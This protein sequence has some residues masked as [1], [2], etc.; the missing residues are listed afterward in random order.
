MVEPVPFAG[1]Y[2]GGE[3]AGGRVCRFLL[4]THPTDGRSSA[5]CLCIKESIDGSNGLSWHPY[6]FVWRL[7]EGVRGDLRAGPDR[8]GRIA[9]RGGRPGLLRTKTK[10]MRGEHEG[11]RIGPL[12][13]HMGRGRTS[14][15]N[16]RQAK[17]RRRFRNRRFRYVTRAAGRGPKASKR[18]EPGGNRQSEGTKAKPRK[19]NDSN[20]FRGSNPG[21]EYEIRTREAVTPTRFPSVRHRPLGEFSMHFLPKHETQLE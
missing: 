1:E 15:T 8:M 20:G 6:A 10:K 12:T 11:I 18:R 17:A 7:S 14:M 5:S 4:R 13:G 21:G 19:P 2:P 3:G 9:L 16:T